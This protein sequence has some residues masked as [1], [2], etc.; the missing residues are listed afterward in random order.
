[1]DIAEGSCQRAMFF[2]PPR[3]AK[4]TMGS[5]NF[6]AWYLGR[7]AGKRVMLASY[8]AEFAAKWGLAAREL[9]A[10]Y[11]PDVFGTR[12]AT[13]HSARSDWGV[14][15]GS[16][17]VTAG[18][19]GS[20]TGRGADVLVIDDPVKNEQEAFSQ[21]YRDKVWD[22]YQA[23]A[24]TRL[25]PGGSV[26]LIMTRWHEDD[27]AGR[28]L[29]TQGDRWRVISLPALAEEDDPLGRKPGEAL[30]PARY[31]ASVLNEIRS[32][33]GSYV[34][35]A[36]Y[37][38]R[39]SLPEGNI[40]KS[41]WWRYWRDNLPQFSEVL[42]AWDMTFTETT[43]GSYVVGQVWG[44]AGADRY[45]LDQVRARMEF[46]QAVA[47]VREMSSRWPEAR[48]KLVEDKAN[49]PAVISVLRRE[50]AGLVPVTPE[51]NKLARAIAVSPSIEAGNVYLPDPTMP[52]YGW[53][54]EFI[55]EWAAFPRGTNDDQVDAGA[56][57]LRRWQGAGTISTG[58]VAR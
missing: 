26:L 10:E 14:S 19:G 18:V 5:R 13:D 42:Q 28:L 33:V 27:L 47:A 16:H 24:R 49:G 57:A 39:P 52:G 38:Q 23:T 41:T 25:E 34:W 21:L 36:L 50:L 7:H 32:E 40:F 31:P 51:G 37:Q 3:H 29:A 9:L 6:P 58:W 8:Q 2:L 46:T 12:V 4:S 22:W 45:L 54:R 44:K 48:L 55:A 30:W 56:H 53:V 35:E 43:S 11:G 20:L 15:N 1:M 17:M